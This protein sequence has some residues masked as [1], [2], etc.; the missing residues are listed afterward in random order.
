M[1][2]YYGIIDDGG[3]E[4]D[5]AKERAIKSIFGL[6]ANL[7]QFPTKRS[8]ALAA[9]APTSAPVFFHSE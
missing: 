1:V 3:V 8:K 7:R 2:D 6:V 5:S 4:T 9:A